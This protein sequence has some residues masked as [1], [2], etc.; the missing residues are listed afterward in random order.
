MM[1]APLYQPG[2]SWL[3]RRSAASKLLCL[4]VAGLVLCLTERLT[5]LGTAAVSVVLLLVCARVELSRLRGPVRAL[6]FL[7]VIVG[8]F[9]AYFHGWHAAAVTVL[10]MAVLVM[11]ATL[12]TLVTRLPDMVGVIE[13]LLGPLDRVGW[14][15]AARIALAMSLAL[16]FIPEIWRNYLEIREAQYARGGAARPLAIIVPLLVRTLRRA[17]EVADAIDARRP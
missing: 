17:D 10:R 15:D 8:A 11:A 14:V 12:V 6:L 3:H 9:A 5:V 16:R 2:Q 7:V 13:R 4:V 1:M